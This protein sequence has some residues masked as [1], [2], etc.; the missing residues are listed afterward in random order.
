MYA[1]IYY[2]YPVALDLLVWV[3]WHTHLEREGVS[4]CVFAYQLPLHCSESGEGLSELRVHASHS[5]F[6]LQQQFS[7]ITASLISSVCLFFWAS[8]YPT[9]RSISSRHAARTASIWA[10]ATASRAALSAA[11][12]MAGIAL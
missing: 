7:F 1:Y 9:L 3:A 8:F 6:D 10:F 5:F 12:S 11:A 4:L 2:M